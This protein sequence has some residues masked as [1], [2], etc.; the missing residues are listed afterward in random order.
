MILVITGFAW[1]VIAST[2][3]WPYVLGLYW[4]R[5][6]RLGTF[7]SMVGGCLTALAWE[8]LKRPLGLHGFI[9]GLAAGLVLY[10]VA[11]LLSP[12]PDPRLVRDAFGPETR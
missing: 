3:L 10:L 4:R 9:P 7:I 1:A 8:A 6:T 2:T 11:S 5:A 12:A